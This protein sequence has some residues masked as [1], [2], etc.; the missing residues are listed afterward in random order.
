MEDYRI[1]V[2]EDGSV[3]FLDAIFCH[4]LRNTVCIELE[5]AHSC[6]DKHF[7][8]REGNYRVLNGERS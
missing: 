8:G 1:F 2:H 5:E 3:A 4:G 6:N 7:Y